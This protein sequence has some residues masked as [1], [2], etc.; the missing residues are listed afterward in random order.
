VFSQIK[1]RNFVLV[2][3]DTELWSEEPTPS[4]SRHGS[5]GEELAEITNKNWEVSKF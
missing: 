1:E 3:L 4:S 5:Q 2:D